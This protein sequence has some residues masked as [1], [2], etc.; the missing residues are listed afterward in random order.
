MR[1]EKILHYIGGEHIPSANGATFGVADPVSNKVYAQAAAGS[2][3]DVDRAVEAAAPAFTAGPWPGMAA[4]ARATVLNKI[5]DAIESRVDDIAS[6]ETF[7]SGLPI[8]QAKGQGAR[9]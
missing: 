6:L 2:H 1:P 8:T 7:D 4:R 9:A 5:G 3:E